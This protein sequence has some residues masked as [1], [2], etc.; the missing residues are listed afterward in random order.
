VPTADAAAGD[1]VTYSNCDAADTA[2]VDSD[3]DD[4][5]MSPIS[6]N[7]ISEEFQIPQHVYEQH[8]LKNSSGSNTNS[9]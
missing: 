8:Q 9:T 3:D 5:M 4:D 1:D 7:D 2:A 6:L